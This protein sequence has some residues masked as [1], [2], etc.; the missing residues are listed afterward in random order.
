[1]ADLSRNAV[2]VERRTPVWSTY[3]VLGDVPFIADINQFSQS[4]E[5][6][7]IFLLLFS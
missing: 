4:T 7:N 3:I 6:K 5:L 1:M 2:T